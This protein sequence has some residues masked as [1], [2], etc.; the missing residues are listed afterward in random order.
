MAIDAVTAALAL[1]LPAVLS[2]NPI[3]SRTFISPNPTV[4][5]EWD[6]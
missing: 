3:T 1:E 5:A 2:I 4:G 6:D